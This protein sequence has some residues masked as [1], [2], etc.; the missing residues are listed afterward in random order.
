MCGVFTSHFFLL[1]HH[2]HS[3][4]F[5][6]QLVG[7]QQVVCASEKLVLFLS[8]F[9]NIRQSFGMPQKKM[10]ER[11]EWLVREF[12][13][14]VR[15]GAAGFFLQSSLVVD[16]WRCRVCNSTSM[17]HHPLVF[18]AAYATSITNWP[19]LAH[20]DFIFLH[21]EYCTIRW[22]HGTIYRRLILPH[23]NIIN[24]IVL[25]SHRPLCELRWIVIVNEK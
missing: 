20:F 8:H 21:F 16:T 3:H 2:L 12:V 13:A 9:S 24:K 7:V 10:T 18:R 25:L 4:F 5:G 1:F 14:V 15:L 19:K 22:Q 6:L 11:N 23:N 17:V